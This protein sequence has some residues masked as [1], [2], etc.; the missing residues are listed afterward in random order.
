AYISFFAFS[1]GPL[2]FVVVSEIFPN[3]VRGRAMSIAIFF[4]WVAVSV[5]SQTFPML[6]EGIGSAW[7]FWIYMSMSAVSFLFVWLSV[8]ETK[9]KTLEEIERLWNVVETD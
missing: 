3:Y 8:P 5:V 6:L 4:L 1:L 2:T 9:G 7:T